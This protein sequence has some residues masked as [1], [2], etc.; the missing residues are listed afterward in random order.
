VTLICDEN[1]LAEHYG[2]AKSDTSDQKNYFQL[3]ILERSYRVLAD[4]AA[5]LEQSTMVR[6]KLGKPE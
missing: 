3:E 5:V 4:S 1:A 6:Q 2:R